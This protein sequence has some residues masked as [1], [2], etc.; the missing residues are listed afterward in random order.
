[1]TE[2]AIHAVALV[3][4]HE[5]SEAIPEQFE[6]RDVEAI[7]RR[8]CERASEWAEGAGVAIANPEPFASGTTAAGVRFEITVGRGGVDQ[9]PAWA[10][11]PRWYR[12]YGVLRE[13][14]RPTRDRG[15]P[16]RDDAGDE[17][18]PVIPLFGPLAP[19]VVT[20]ADIARDNPPRF[21]PQR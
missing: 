1:M 14:M 9:E 12:W 11:S 7:V 17:L 13:V 18:A 15:A 21:G 5:I 19:V 2:V 16:A 10:W 6:S 3:E 20:P 4:R 8:C